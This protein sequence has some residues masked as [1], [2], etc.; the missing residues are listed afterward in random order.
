M[1]QAVRNAVG[2]LDLPLDQALAM[3][4]SAPAAFLGQA[5]RRGRI[6]P[7]LAAD[8]VWL[9]AGLTVRG[10]WIDGRFEAA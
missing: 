4:A 1:A 9:D 2:L 8:L 3:A 5:D 6:A 10:T 7:G